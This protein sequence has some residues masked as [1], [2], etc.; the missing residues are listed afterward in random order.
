M[1][2][3]RRKGGIEVIS[4]LQILRGL[5]ALGV[6]FYH[7]DFRLPGDWHTE[8]FG[9]PTFF[10]ISGFIMCFIT[11]DPEGGDAT[12]R[13]FMMRRVIRIVPFYWLCTFALIALQNRPP[14]TRHIDAILAWASLNV[15]HL[16]RSLFFVP[17]ETFPMLGVGWT[18]NF[19][20]YF[21]VVFAFAILLSRTFAPVIAAGIV[22]A[23]FK[24]NAAG[25]DSWLIKFYS[26]GYIHFFLDGITLFYVWWFTKDHLKKFSIWVRLPVIVICSLIV[27]V[28]YGSQFIPPQQELYPTSLYFPVLLV[29]AAIFAASAGADITWRPLVLLGDASYAIYL[30]H[31]ITMEEFRHR[32]PVWKES[33]WSTVLIMII[34]TAVG[35]L[36]HLYIEKP[37]LRWIR[38]R[39][40]APAKS[41]P[42]K[43]VTLVGTGPKSA[44]DLFS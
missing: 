33:L 24:A 9:V 21:Y 16:V 37:M 10:V 11:R 26:H 7:I 8:F 34:A 38:N 29:A 19:E 31:T 6:V 36:V 12:A 41:E 43:A 1:Q 39:L 4:N 13:G 3:T 42:E 23:V 15:P 35:I 5:S 17:S 18:L 2:S 20:A 27:V 30:T 22:Y 14:I 28:V 32:M 25:V 40:W 44:A